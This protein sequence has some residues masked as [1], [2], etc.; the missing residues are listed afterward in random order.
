[1]HVWRGALPHGEV[2]KLGELISMRA[3]G[4]SSDFDWRKNARGDI[5]VLELFQC[6][7]VGAAQMRS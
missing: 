7:G 2:K 1:M 5:L 3:R 4:H 6:S